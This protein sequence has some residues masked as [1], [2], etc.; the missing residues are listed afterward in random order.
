MNSWQ[1]SKRLGLSLLVIFALA[2]SSR[3]CVASAQDQGDALKVDSSPLRTWSSPDAKFKRE[4]KLTEIM[5]DRVKLE[6]ADGKSTVAQAAKLSQAD[7]D[8]IASERKRAEE[9]A[10]S[11]FM[12][13]EQGSSS[14]GS[15]SRKA[16]QVIRP[17]THAGV[18]LVSADSA[19]TAAVHFFAAGTRI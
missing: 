19:K 2:D 1:K 6:M 10:D 17:L 8:F 11:P 5:G 4:A 12:D 18:R 13:K 14:G 9:N 7:Q 15:A 3:G 16:W